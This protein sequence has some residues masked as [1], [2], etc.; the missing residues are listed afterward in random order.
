MRAEFGSL[1]AAIAIPERRAV[2]VGAPVVETVVASSLPTSGLLW[3]PE[4]RI[5]WQHREGR[6]VSGHF[7]WMQAATDYLAR[8]VEKAAD[9]LVIPVVD[10]RARPKPPESIINKP[11]ARE[12]DTTWRQRSPLQDYYGVMLIVQQGE[13]PARV[14][15]SLQEY[16]GMPDTDYLGRPTLISGNNGNPHSDPSFQRNKV[17]I[18]FDYDGQFK[19]GEVQI[20]DEAGWEN[21]QVTRAGYEVRRGQPKTVYPVNLRGE[22]SIPE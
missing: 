14:A 9:E 21:Y 13:N 10:I 22:I 11:L 6:N 17:F 2:S 15:R 19:Q 16:Y 4:F 7:E 18:Y 20:Y 8:S 12:P 3:Q 5:A 1:G